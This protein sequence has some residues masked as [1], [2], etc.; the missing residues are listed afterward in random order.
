[1]WYIRGR[2]PSIASSG[3]EPSVHIDR[4]E[5]LAVAALVLEVALAPRGV[6]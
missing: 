3:P 4:L 2:D 5:V 1:M 6:D